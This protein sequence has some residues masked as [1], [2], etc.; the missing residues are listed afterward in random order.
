MPNSQERGVE[1]AERQQPVPG[2]RREA[3]GVCY[4]RACAVLLRSIAPVR[5]RT[6][7]SL[8]SVRLG[9]R[10][11]RCGEFLPGKGGLHC[12]HRKPVA[13][14]PAVAL[15]PLNY[16][17][18]CPLATTLEPRTGTPRPVRLRVTGQSARSEPPMERAVMTF[19]Q[20]EQRVAA[21]VAS[22]VRSGTCPLCLSKL[23]VVVA[24]D[25]AFD[26]HV[27]A[28]LHDM[29]QR[30]VD[31]LDGCKCEQPQDAAQLN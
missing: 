26:H 27:V 24:I 25:N 28:E 22:E 23:M 21:F 11:Q 30:C 18:A 12:H 31:G 14:N 8:P 20:I 1:Q 2:M 4:P 16:L 3:D 7:A 9:Y 5:G 17:L 13:D 6:P 19:E 29:L 10:C 15:E